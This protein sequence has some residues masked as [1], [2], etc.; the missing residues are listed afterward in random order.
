MNAARIPSS[1]GIISGGRAF[2]GQ[3]DNF[4]IPTRVHKEGEG[5][6][7]PPTDVQDSV[8]GR[9]IP[10]LGQLVQHVSYVD[11]KDVLFG[12]YIN[13]V[14][15][16]H[17]NLES[18]AAILSEKSYEAIV[19]VLSNTPAWVLSWLQMRK[20]RWRVVEDPKKLCRLFTNVFSKPIFWYSKA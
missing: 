10:T 16:W 1:R 3:G 17:S 2:E 4:R 5:E 11:D 6:S 8:W 18:T 15:T 14:V 19:S 12:W 7:L 13:P 9:P 20:V